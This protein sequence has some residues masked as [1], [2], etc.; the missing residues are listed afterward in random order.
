M[1]QLKTLEYNMATLENA[2]AICMICGTAKQDTDTGCC[3]NGHDDWL[4]EGDDLER[5]ISAA[6]RFN[7]DLAGLTNAIK[8]NKNLTC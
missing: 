2:D 6:K 1:N 7:T 4:E 3:E 5:F 8:N